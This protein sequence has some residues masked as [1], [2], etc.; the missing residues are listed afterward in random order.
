MP[1]KKKPTKSEIVENIDNNDI[2]TTSVK[3]LYD[4]WFLGY[5]S[6]VIL[7]RAIPYIND[8]LKPVQRRI[9]H[10][11]KLMDDGRFH[12]VANVIGQTMQFHPHGDASIGDA[13]VKIGQKELLLDT[14]GN[15]GDIRTGDK[16]AAPR[17]IETRL[18]KFALEVAFNKDTTEWELA[19]DGRKNE[20]VTLPIKFPLL[21]AQGAEGIAVGLSTKILPHNFIELIKASIEVLKGR[22]VK[23]VPDFPTGGMMDPSDYNRGKQ[24]GK[25]R[26]RAC[27]NAIDKKTLEITEIPFSTTTNSLIDSII[28]AN[29]K[30]KIKIKKVIDNTAADVSI[31]IQLAPGYSPDIAVDALY[32]FTD[33]EKSISPNACVIVEDKPHF[34]SVNDILKISTLKTKDLLKQELELRKLALE[35]KWHFSSLEKIFIENRIY[36]DIEEAETWEEVIGNID[37]GLKPFKKLLKRKVTEEDIVRLTEIKIKRISKFDAFKADEAIN[38]LEEEMKEVKHHLKNLTDYAI[39]YFQNLLEKYGEGKERKT[40]IKVFDSINKKSVAAANARIYVNRKDG[41]IGTG[42]RKDEFLFE[43]SDV[44]DIIAFT[45][46][47]HFMVSKVSDKTFVGKNIVH[48]D[49]WKKGDDRTVYNMMYVDLEAKRTYVKRFAVSSV[50]RNKLYPLS[51]SGKAKTLWLTA[52]ANGESELI[53]VQLS[54]N[55]RAHNKNFQYDFAD[56]D[57]KSRAS[58]GN[59]ITKY[60]VRKVTLLEKGTSSLGKVQIWLDE[61][62]GRLNTD[63]R[64]RLLGE[65]D[66]GD[67]I[68]V[69]Y[70][71]GSFELTD[72]E[73]TNK[74][75]MEKVLHI[76][77]YDP[78]AVVSAVYPDLDSDIYF[79]KRFSI[80]DN[81]TNKLATFLPEGTKLKNTILSVDDKTY[82]QFNEKVG[83]GIKT[84]EKELSELISVKGHKAQGNKLNKG[85][86]TKLKRIEPPQKAETD[87]KSDDDNDLDVGSQLEWDFDK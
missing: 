14:Q 84:R 58:K 23:L 53:S 51:K 27:I 24:G 26:V 55:C 82:I 10:S 43:C 67:L 66:T 21:L 63:E 68:S 33:C 59:I 69:V 49:I 57:I 74:Y 45:G 71:N 86:I 40:E 81:G 70:S 83:K 29:D 38:K 4:E 47:G 31:I 48:I 42:L 77:F 7:E 6:Y 20:P 54:P 11:L 50:T 1:S 80:E 85:A 8:G 44:D 17:Y 61:T 15:W 41:F 87:T 73:L 30:G 3:S 79:V 5:A 28:K 64:G 78:E 72:F 9:L 39:S 18:T 2:E 25:I 22:S 56:L 75:E 46:D 16:S 60:P 52:N 12:K 32:A 62:V 13:L 34:L 35:D 36:R 65:F 19:Y 37:K 76:G